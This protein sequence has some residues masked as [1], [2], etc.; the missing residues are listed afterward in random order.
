MM[1][2]IQDDPDVTPRGRP[3]FVALGLKTMGITGSVC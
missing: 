2:M 1:V 3:D